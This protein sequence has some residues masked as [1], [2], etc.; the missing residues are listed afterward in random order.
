[1]PPLRLSGFAGNVPNGFPTFSPVDL[2]HRVHAL[3]QQF[4]AEYSGMEL[5]PS[6]RR[7]S[8]RPAPMPQGSLSDAEYTDY[9]LAYNIQNQEVDAY[10]SLGRHLG[11]F[12]PPA[13]APL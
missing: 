3:N 7:R 9:M 10:E 1:L 4:I 8:E 2:R 12:P 6:S 5:L 13:P 11:L